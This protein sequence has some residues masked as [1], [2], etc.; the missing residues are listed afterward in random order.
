M[1]THM[2]GAGSKRKNRKQ[3]ITKKGTG[4]IQ[5]KRTTQIKLMKHITM[6]MHMQDDRSIFQGGR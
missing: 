2:K 6:K 5:M 1:K 4:E 3:K